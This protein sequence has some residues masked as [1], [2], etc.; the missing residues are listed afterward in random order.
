MIPIKS[1]LKVPPAA[2]DRPGQPEPPGLSL[3]RHGGAGI[4]RG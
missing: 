4:S 2:G 3:P 1:I